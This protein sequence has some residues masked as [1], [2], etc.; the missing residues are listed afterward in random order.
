MRSRHFLSVT[1]A[2]LVAAPAWAQT[3]ATERTKNPSQVIPA[4]KRTATKGSTTKGKAATG[5]VAMPDPDLL[6]GTLYEAEKRP[7]HGMLSEIEMGEEESSQK[8]DK[9]S[10]NSGDPGAGGEK[11]P[12]EQQGGGGQKPPEEQKEGGSSEKVPEGPQAQPEGVQV[13]N[14]E[15]PEGAQGQQGG[16]QSKPRDMQIGDATLQIQTTQASPNVVGV[17]SSSAQQYEKKVPAGQ[18]TDNRNRGVEKGKEM[19]KGL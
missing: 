6:D 17:Q 19:P 1:L 10:P 9:V 8:S 14:L 16:E 12:E 7:L 4:A 15:V 2:V 5:K 11:P 18:Q 3:S 13:A